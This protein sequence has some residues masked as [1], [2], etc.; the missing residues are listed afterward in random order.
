MEIIIL[1]KFMILVKIIVLIANHGFL[2]NY[3]KVTCEPGMS[4]NLDIARKT[5]GAAIQMG[6][7][8]YST[9]PRPRHGAFST[10]ITDFCGF[11]GNRN[12]SMHVMKIKILVKI[13]FF[14]S[15]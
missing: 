12:I 10:G 6:N 9:P 14:T 2:R 4:Q 13:S 7:I 11:H 5:M 3:K 1:V 15:K 8:N